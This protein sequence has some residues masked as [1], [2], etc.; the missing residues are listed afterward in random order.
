MQFNGAAVP[1]P[2]STVLITFA[3]LN[4]SFKLTYPPVVSTLQV[5]LTVNGCCAL[6]LIKESGSSA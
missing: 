6:P 2:G 4:A 5:T 1:P 3:T